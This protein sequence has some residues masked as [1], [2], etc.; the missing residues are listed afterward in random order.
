M[1]RMCS[2]LMIGLTLVLAAC[3]KTNP[4]LEQYPDYIGQWQS[5]HDSLK[6]E[7]NGQVTY[8]HH[9]HQDQK[10]PES[11]VSLTEQADMK[12]SITQFDENS[13]AIGQGDLGK[14]FKVDHTPYQENEQWKMQVNGQVYTKQ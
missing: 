9:A 5:Q 12:A 8:K 3:G 1:K 11:E 13:F 2:T 7:K 4:M 6:I 14:N 10:T